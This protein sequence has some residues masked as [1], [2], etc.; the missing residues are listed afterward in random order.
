MESNVASEESGKTEVSRTM[1]SDIT[2]REQAKEGLHAFEQQFS[3]AHSIES[4]GIIAGGIAHDFSNIL[5]PS[6]GLPKC[7]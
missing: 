2:L 3:R 6:W 7:P 1:V 5:F 4:I